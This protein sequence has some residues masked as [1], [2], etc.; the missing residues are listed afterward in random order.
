MKTRRFDIV[1]C[2]DVISQVKDPSIAIQEF[3][4][5]LKP[6]GILVLNVAAYQW[7]WS[8]HDTTCETQHRFRRSQLRTLIEENGLKPMISSYAN[9]ILFP[10]IITRRKIFPPKMATSDVKSYS[11]FIDS[12]FSAIGILENSWIRIGGT[13]PT[14]CSVYLAATKR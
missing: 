1:V 14:G 6:N 13:F 7:M 9:M 11:P 10:L 3:A 8:Y 2:A 5:V 4:R 12:V